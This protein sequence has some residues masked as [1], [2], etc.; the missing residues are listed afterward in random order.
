MFLENELI[1]L[2]ALEPEDLD[3]LYK[4]ENNSNLWVHGNTLTPYSKLALR[5]YISETQQTDIFEA[6]QLRLMIELKQKK[7]VL[8]S[9]DI[10]DFDFHN[11][12]V[13]I[14]ILIDEQMRKNG[15]AEQT[16]KL[17][18]DY[19]FN[20]LHIHQLYAYIATDNENSIRLF[21]K[22]RYKKSGLLK[23]WI[24]HNNAYKDVSLYQ[25]INNLDN[26]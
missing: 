23:N 25:L 10:Y 4:W 12:R 1:R 20:F 5:N 11:S 2:R 22:C 9:V 24:R 6:K 8:G 21:E 19:S 14:G 7:I 18:E 15:Y 26:E 13:G 17:I 16:L 3:I